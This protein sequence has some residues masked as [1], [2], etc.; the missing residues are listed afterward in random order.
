MMNKTLWIPALLLIFGLAGLACE[1]DHA[2]NGHCDHYAEEPFEFNVD[3]QDQVRFRLVGMTG[4]VEI[5]GQS[6][7]EVITIAGE[8]RVGASSNSEARAHLDDIEVDVQDGD[9]DV[10]IRTIYHGDAED[11]CYEVNYRITLPPD[12]EVRVTNQVGTVTVEEMERN[13]RASVVTGGV[14]LDHVHGDADID[15][16][17]GNVELEDFYGSASA[18]LTTGNL[19]CR[20]YLPPE[21]E[22]DLKTITGQ[23]TVYLPESTSAHLT[24]SLATGQ[25]SIAN[26]PLED[27]N[28]SDNYISGRLG[29]GEGT[30]TLLVITGQLSIFGFGE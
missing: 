7:V 20:A 27:P 24:A 14:I 3:M 16:T 26:L 15:V 13:V 19:C 9:D 23:M 2:V 17:T 10:R 5:T 4:T 22:L 25:I 6:G 28:I 29:D 11:R 18:D 12:L 30:I 21:G 8:R 1:D